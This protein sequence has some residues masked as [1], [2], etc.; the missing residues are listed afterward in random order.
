MASYMRNPMFGQDSSYDQG[1]D[2]DSGWSD[3]SGEPS[4]PS[5]TSEPEGSGLT[6]AQW[7]NIG[8]HVLDTLG[9]I[10]QPDAYQQPVDAGYVGPAYA[11]SA[12]T[13]APIVRP[14]SVAAAGSI[15]SNVLLIGGL[16]LA[17]LFLFRKR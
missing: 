2:Y 12:G 11:P 13:P 5:Y 3:Y 16:G 8:V 7:A 15:D 10:I 9:R 17:A 1:W 4:T 6:G 14:G